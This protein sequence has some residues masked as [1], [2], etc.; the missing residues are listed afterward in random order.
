MTKG[1]ALSK[2]ETIVGRLAD[3][4]IDIVKTSL[5]HQGKSVSIVLVACLKVLKKDIEEI[6]DLLEK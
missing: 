3:V 1:Q 2:A 6:I 4:N 5:H